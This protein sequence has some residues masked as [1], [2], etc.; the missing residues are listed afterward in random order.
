MSV[1]LVVIIVMLMLNVPTLLG[2]SPVP[3]TKDT[4]E[5]G[6]TVLVSYL[7]QPNTCVNKPIDVMYAYSSCSPSPLPYWSDCLPY[8][9]LH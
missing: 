4:V 6:L 1:E 7:I 5:M 8:G 2:A 9:H 3:V